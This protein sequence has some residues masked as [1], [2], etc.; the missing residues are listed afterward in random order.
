MIKVRGER[1]ACTPNF[2][3]TPCTSITYS[4]FE[5]NVFQRPCARVEVVI[6][7]NDNLSDGPHEFGA[8]RHAVLRQIRTI[9][10]SLQDFHIFCSA[11]FFVQL[12]GT[13]LVDLGNGWIH[14]VRTNARYDQQV[15]SFFPLTLRLTSTSRT[16]VTQLVY[17]PAGLT[18]RSIP[19]SQSNKFLT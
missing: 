9:S 18:K 3:P 13:K 5:A 12:G 17:E 16:K 6:Q 15:K 19:K 7:K 1:L 14:Y 8:G 10:T 4:R 2:R 11:S